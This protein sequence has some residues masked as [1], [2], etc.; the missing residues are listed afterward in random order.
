MSIKEIAE[1]F[2]V[3]FEPKTKHNMS[4][5]DVLSVTALLVAGL[6]VSIFVCWLI[7]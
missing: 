1:E 2:K 5:K 4:L 6:A 3:D 7:I